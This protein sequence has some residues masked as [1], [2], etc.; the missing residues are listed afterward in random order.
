MGSLSSFQI[1]WM[2]CVRTL[3]YLPVCRIAPSRSLGPP[4]PT[5][6]A[7]KPSVI[8]KEESSQGI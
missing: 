1:Q 6:I 2:F 5:A 4:K 8:I 7:D 3:A